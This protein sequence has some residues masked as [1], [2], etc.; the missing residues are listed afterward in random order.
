MDNN[1][2]NIVNE[3]ER[4]KTVKDAEPEL[5]SYKNVRLD[6]SEKP[7]NTKKVVEIILALVVIAIFSSA[8]ITF[9]KN[10]KNILRKGVG[11]LIN[12]IENPIYA[13]KGSEFLQ[14]S[15]KK[16]FKTSIIGS[17]QTTFNK[18]LI[19]ENELKFLQ[20]I[21]D[22]N[23]ALSYDLN[24]PAKKGI[25]SFKSTIDGNNIF[26]VNGNI[27]DTGFTYKIKNVLSKYVLVD[28]KGIEKIF[29]SKQEDKRDFDVLKSIAL[30]KLYAKIEEKDLKRENITL[31]E[32]NIK[33]DDVIYE[34]KN[35]TLKKLITDTVNELIKDEK[36]MEKASVYFN[37]PKTRL[38][39][40]IL[41]QTENL[42][43]QDILKEDI[44]FHTYVKGITNNFIGFKIE[45]KTNSITYLKNGH[46]IVLSVKEDNKEEFLLK[47]TKT[48]EEKTYI[49]YKDIEFNAIKLSKNNSILY[50]YTLKNKKNNYEGSIV[51]TEE[52][53]N[54]KD[55][56]VRIL[57]SKLNED[58]ENIW[59][60]TS[61]IS[62]N[63]K[64]SSDTVSFEDEGGNE[65]NNDTKNEVIRRTLNNENLKA[66]TE[67]FKT[68]IG[69]QMN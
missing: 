38:K 6:Y 42:L 48:D 56:N 62:Y 37:T 15:I 35:E 9:Q 54:Y 14:Y 67:E 44:V 25:Y 59:N 40:I 19:D 30:K 1:V 33:A 51:I 28:V 29:I 60:L 36:F 2:P 24:F 11:A 12:V 10:N 50:D 63:V 39:E 34:I 20:D 4:I 46:N 32:L 58:H 13:V 61:T 66:L 45:T 18:E 21:K 3:Q 53:K 27:T 8:L 57:I 68:F 31:D 7:K 64:N 69:V 26:E 22:V 49:K 5:L 55:G 16:E 47:K 41:E 17:F 65:I 52:D 43:K 23:T